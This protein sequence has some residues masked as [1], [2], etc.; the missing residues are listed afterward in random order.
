M[1]FLGIDAGATA[2]KWALRDSEGVIRSGK[3]QAMDGH[4]YR[5]E[6]AQRIDDV[7]S[8]IA[9][10]IPS[11]EVTAICAG[12]TGL[13]QSPAD[14]AALKALFIK[15]FPKATVTLMTDIELAYRAHLKPGEGILLYAGTGSVAMHIS[16]SS[17]VI[18]IGG[19]G[20]L[21][22]D[23]GAGYWIGREA[24]R[25]TVA[26]IE[27]GLND[28]FASAICEVLDAKDWA[29]I[30]SIVYGQERSVIAGLTPV[31]AREALNSDPIAISIL[32][33]AAIELTALITRM[34]KVTGVSG[35]KI[36]FTGGIA[37]QVP[38]IFTSLSSRLGDRVTLGDIDIAEGASLLAQN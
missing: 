33:R 4:I 36:I 34:D 27:D 30:R 1:T 18:R 23:E 28:H 32:D 35:M 16:S 17:E 5:P 19:W 31:V 21:L 15:H 24:I 2:A 7:L 13:A 37:H 26:A 38:Q 9:S 22:G 29:E 11:Q 8:E 6:S 14:Q 25:H 3:S 10:Q 20:Y 12:F